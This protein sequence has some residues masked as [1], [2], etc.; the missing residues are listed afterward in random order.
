M[1]T[2]S[3]NPYRWNGN[4]IKASYGSSALPSIVA[5]VEKELAHGVL[6]TRRSSAT[7]AGRYIQSLDI[8][9]PYCETIEKLVDWDRIRAAN[10]ICRGPQ[11]T[12]GARALARHQ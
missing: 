12:R 10:L 9:T 2:A 11:C 8:L 5:Q 1:I 7:C 4:E 6:R 3:H